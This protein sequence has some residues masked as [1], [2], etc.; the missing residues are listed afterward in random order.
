[1]PGDRC[2]AFRIPEKRL[3]CLSLGWWLARSGSATDG[4]VDS[5]SLIESRD[6]RRALG[7]GCQPV[8]FQDI[9]GTAEWP[10]AGCT[11]DRQRPA[12]L[13]HTLTALPAGAQQAQG[14]AER[15]CARHLL[16]CFGC[17]W[18]P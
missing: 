8:C 11:A 10:C 17:L 13:G 6:C 7:S 15:L 18:P 2:S 3:P 1:M 16:I 5:Q 4:Q 12:I 9:A 14:E